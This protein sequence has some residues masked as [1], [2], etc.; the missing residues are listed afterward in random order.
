M[1]TAA[2]YTPPTEL[3]LA[4]EK[5]LAQ[6]SPDKLATA[7]TLYHCYGGV[8]GGRSAVNGAELPSFEKCPV[9]VRA[10]WLAVAEAIN[11]P[12]ASAV[13]PGPVV[14][15]TQKPSVGRIVNFQH[16]DTPTAALVTGVNDD[17]TVSLVVFPPDESHFTTRAE[18]APEGTTEPAKW[19]WPPRA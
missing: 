1:S 16:G 12:V 5:A 2:P 3:I 7:L 19:S 11:T 6:A 18:Q 8:T 10:G 17:S 4:A 9:L 15:P 14:P 13:P